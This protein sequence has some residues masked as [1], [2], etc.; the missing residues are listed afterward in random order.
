MTPTDD[1]G[2]RRFRKV[3]F[4][5]PQPCNWAAVSS[6]FFDALMAFSERDV[7]LLSIKGV[8]I[9]EIADMR[10]TRV[11]TI[12]A[13]NAAIY[14]KSGVSNR[15]ERAKGVF[16]LDHLA[17]CH[18]HWLDPGQSFTWSLARARQGKKEASWD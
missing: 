6:L 12:K 11:G 1:D 15:A 9:S 10:Q 17:S 3:F 8:S 2:R 14:R 18:K 16:S 7:A 13:Q 4:Y 5:V